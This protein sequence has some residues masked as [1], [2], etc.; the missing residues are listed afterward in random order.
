MNVNVSLEV[1][2]LDQSEPSEKATFFASGVVPLALQSI[3]A[4]LVSGDRLKSRT[5]EELSLDT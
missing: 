5:R 3:P 2:T 4:T 1:G